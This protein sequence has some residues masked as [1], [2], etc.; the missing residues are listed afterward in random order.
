MSDSATKTTSPIETALDALRAQLSTKVSLPE[1]AISLDEL[2]RL[3]LS[4]FDL[5]VHIERLR[6]TNDATKQDELT[7]DNCL[8]ALDI[9]YMSGA[10]A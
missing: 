8:E 6:A 3:G 10:P 7:E 2:E 1:I 5:V 4:K 9:L